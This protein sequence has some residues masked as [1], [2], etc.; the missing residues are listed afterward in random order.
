M[1]PFDAARPV[2]QLL[3][4]LIKA[5]QSIHNPH[6]IELANARLN[7]DTSLCVNIANLIL[8]RNISLPMTVEIREYNKTPCRLIRC[9]GLV[10]AI[11]EATGDPGTLCRWIKRD[12]LLEPVVS[13]DDS[14]SCTSSIVVKEITWSDRSGPR[15]C[16]DILHDDADSPWIERNHWFDWDRIRTRY[17]VHPQILDTPFTETIPAT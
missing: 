16:V 7:S 4:I 9:L 15:C 10:V 5:R 13:D 6:Q 14:E 3:D 11:T 1:E 8:G 2:A 12:D 17:K